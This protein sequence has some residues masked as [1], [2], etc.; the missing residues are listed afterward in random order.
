[1]QENSRNEAGADSFSE[2]ESLL[3]MPINHITVY[4]TFLEGLLNEYKAR[5]LLAEDFKTIAAVEIEMKKLQKMVT[6]NYTLNSMKGTAV[7]ISH[8]VAAN[9]IISVAYILQS[10][11]W[12][13][14]LITYSDEI[15]ID[16]SKC[17]IMILEKGL[18]CARIR[19]ST[20]GKSIHFAV[21]LRLIEI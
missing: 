7:S 12:K 17:R 13:F 11:V 18:V 10:V 1:M 14:G 8:D 4:A 5:D 6:E 3:L 2:I 20:V 9:R 15:S 19:L 16:F 21:E